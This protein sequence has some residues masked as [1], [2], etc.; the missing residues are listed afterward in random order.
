MARDVT[1]LPVAPFYRLIWD[2]RR[3]LRLRQR[4]ASSWKRQIAAFNPDDVDGYRRFHAYSEE[5]YQEG[6]VK[7]GTVPFLSFGQMMRAAP[8]LMRLQAYAVVHAKVVR[9]SSR[10]RT[11]ARRFPSHAAGRRQSRSTSR[12]SM[13]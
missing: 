1:L 5:V 10:T 4:S 6:Y 2:G 8:A 11:C 13:R 12:R 7:L 3:R 9:A